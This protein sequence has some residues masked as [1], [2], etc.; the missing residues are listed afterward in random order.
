MTVALEK[1]FSDLARDSQRVFRAI[2]NAMARPGSIVDVDAGLAPP[3]PL[4][5]GAA[6]LA[7]ALCDFETP[8]WLDAAMANEATRGYLRF[9][10]GAPIVEAP[11]K[12]AFALIASPLGLPDLNAFPL[13]SLEY[14]DASATLIVQVRNLVA[15]GGWRLSGPGI[16]GETSF[17]AAPL[18]RDFVAR[19]AA[20]HPKFPRGLD[21]IFVAEGSAA[22]LPRTT[23]IEA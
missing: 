13:G 10:T 18:P 21:I 5:T 20:L 2:M 15:D 14:P 19:R 7:L 8:L 6:A 16:D 11:E 12:A 9:H 22:A 4:T 23:R 17:E 1:G 3:E